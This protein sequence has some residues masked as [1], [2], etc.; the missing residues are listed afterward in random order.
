[1]NQ[2]LADIK[3]LE[4]QLLELKLNAKHKSTVYSK[5]SEEVIEA[6]KTLGAYLHHPHPDSK[7]CYWFIYKS[8]TNPKVSIR[9][10]GPTI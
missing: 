7:E 3:L 2:T 5:N 4:N 6:S 9:V 8:K 1:M 10:K